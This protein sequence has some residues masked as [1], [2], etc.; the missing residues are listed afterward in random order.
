MPV[1]YAAHVSRFATTEQ[2]QMPHSP[3]QC[4]CHNWTG[5]HATYSCMPVSHTTYDILFATTEQLQMPHTAACQSLMQ[6]MTVSLP[7]LNRYR[8][9]TQ[10]YASLSC[11]PWQ[12]VC[13]NWTATDATYSCMSGC[14]YI[15]AVT[16]SWLICV[17]ILFMW[18]QNMKASYMVVFRVEETFETA[19]AVE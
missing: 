6:P 13:H 2:L 12:S 5:T 19:A 9:H 16:A 7:H 8:C 10:L 3:W 15:L 11:N 14:E 4:V 17:W 1:S 18:Y